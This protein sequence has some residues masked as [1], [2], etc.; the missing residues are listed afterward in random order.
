M[1]Q[2]ILQQLMCALVVENILQQIGLANNINIGKWLPFIELNNSVNIFLDKSLMSPPG[3][4]IYA[5]TIYS[6]LLIFGIFLI[7][8]RDA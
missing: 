1:E 7:S 6:I 8:K 3:G 4:Q 5:A 2:V